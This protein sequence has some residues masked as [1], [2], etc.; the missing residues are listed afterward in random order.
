LTVEQDSPEQGL[1]NM[2][3]RIYTETVVEHV[4]SP[5]NFGNLPGADGYGT[6]A[7]PDGDTVR[8]WLR[9]KDDLVT[10]ASFW[11]NAC[12]A[13]IASLSMVTD[14]TRGKTPADALAIS[15]QDVLEAL[16]GLPEGNMHCAGLAVSVL[17]EAVKDYLVME[18]EPWKRSYRKY[19]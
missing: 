19:A 6:I 7:T 18:R 8:F 16:G 1:I 9:V 5:R 10:D 4:L 3:R 17:R 12:A 15:Q 13:T 11:T 2:M 14:L